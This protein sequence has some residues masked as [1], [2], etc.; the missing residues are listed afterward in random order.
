M[1][2]KQEANAFVK[3]CITAAL[4]QM[5]KTQ[6]LESISITELTRKAG[7]GRV[8]FYRNFESKEDVIRQYLAKITKEWGE[9]FE[10]N[11][12]EN[13][14]ESLF[15]HYQRH[16]DIFILLYKAGLWHLSLQSVKDAC[17]PKPEQDN[18]SAYQ[19]AFLAYGLYGWLEEWF[20]RGLTETPKEMQ[21]LLKSAEME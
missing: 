15:S 7:V 18:R 20:K 4:F 19:S 13:L 9:A 17:G 6:A 14:I 3:E 11:P 16:K 12:S 21:N 5:L 1:N 10:R 2:K 8:S